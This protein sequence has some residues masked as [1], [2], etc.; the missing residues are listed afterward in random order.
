[1]AGGAGI[2]RQWVGHVFRL[3]AL[4]TINR[5]VFALEFIIRPVVVKLV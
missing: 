4:F 1:M 2:V 5:N 3:V